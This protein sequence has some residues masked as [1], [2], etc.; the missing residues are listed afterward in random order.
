M[1]YVNLNFRLSLNIYQYILVMYD[2]S[3]YSPAYAHA[4]YGHSTALL[5]DNQLLLYGG[6]LR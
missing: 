2:M 6:C 1:Q 4:R 3:S 5:T